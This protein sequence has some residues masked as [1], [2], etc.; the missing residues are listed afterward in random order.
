M[1][2]RLKTRYQEEVAPALMKRFGWDNVMRVPRL[3]KIVLNM[4]VGE[5]AKDANL[6]DAAAKQMGQ[7]CGQRPDVRRAKKSISAFRQLRKGHPVGC[8]A[9][10]RGQRMYEFLDRLISVALP[11]IRDFR[12]LPLNAFDG[13]GNYSF[14]IREQVIFPEI[15][16]DSIDRVRGMDITLTSSARTDEEARELLSTLGIPFQESR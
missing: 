16:Y 11:R 7:I 5:G 14:G 10:L 8:R 12:G 15:D 3:E 1:A 6:I 13:R 2:S 4:G 9:T